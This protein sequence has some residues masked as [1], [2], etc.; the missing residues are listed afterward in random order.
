MYQYHVI[1]NSIDKKRIAYGIKAMFF[2]GTK[3]TEK[4]RIPDICSDFNT[5]TEIAALCTEE[6]L[7][8]IH[9]LDV[10]RDM[11]WSRVIIETV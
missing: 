11:L 10:I 3:E 8:P 9:L 5:V 4:L 6:Q 7:E 2:D 1:K